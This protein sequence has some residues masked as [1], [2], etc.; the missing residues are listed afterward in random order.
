[1]ADDYEVGFGKPPKHTQFKPGTTGNAKGRPKGSKNLKTDLLE[2][3]SEKI[4]IKQDGTPMT[5]SKQKALLKA[6]MAQ[7]IQGDTKSATV[8]LNLVLK[9][10]QEEQTEVE[11][12]DL[13]AADM[14]ILQQFEA[15]VLA[16]A[17]AKE[18]KN[19]K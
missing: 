17:K 5:V 8:V 19:V 15:D 10:L 11:A 12:I 16:A 18:A 1:M 9:L 2:E 4:A 13:T 7:A 6:L 3:L 14:Q